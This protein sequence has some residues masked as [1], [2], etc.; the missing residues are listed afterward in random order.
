MK[1]F[2]PLVAVLALLFGFFGVTSAQAVNETKSDISQQKIHKIDINS[3]SAERLTALPGIGLKKAKAI[4]AYRKQNGKFKSVKELSNVKG[5]GK[6]MLVKL[7]PLTTA[8]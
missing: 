8:K 5:I 7:T 2:I 4:V 3:A 6:K 1:T